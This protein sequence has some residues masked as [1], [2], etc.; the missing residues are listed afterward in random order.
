MVVADW[1]HPKHHIVNN[2]LNFRLHR[3]SQLMRMMHFALHFDVWEEASSGYADFLSTL[4]FI[5][6][7]L[8]FACESCTEW[9][10]FVL[11]FSH[12]VYQ[13]RMNFFFL[14]D[15]LLWQSSVSCWR[16]E[17]R[18]EKMQ[19]PTLFLLKS[20]FLSSRLVVMMCG[21]IEWNHRP[22]LDMITFRWGFSMWIFIPESSI[23]A[24]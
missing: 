12:I 17:G 14:G 2:K 11:K 18:K 22:L 9:V 23:Y 16:K 6:V 1:S 4:L 15:T 19:Q 21:W 7:H 10:V 24:W 13:S 5:C 8:S 20:F 3:V